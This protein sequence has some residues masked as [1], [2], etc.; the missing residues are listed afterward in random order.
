MREHGTGVRNIRR[1]VALVSAILFGAAAAHEARAAISFAGG[2]A[3]ERF[4][5]YVAFLERDP[6]RF[7]AELATVRQLE[8]SDVEY[9]LTTGGTFER[10]VEGSLTTDGERVLVNVGD[11]KGLSVNSRIAHELEHAR[12]FDDGEIAFEQSP[13]TGQW[14]AHHASYD[15]GDEVRAWTVQLR[16]SV[17]TDFWRRAKGEANP[18]PSMLGEFAKAETDEQR[19]EVL[20]ARGYGNRRLVFGA[21]VTFGASAGYEPRQLVRPAAGRRFF[22]RVRSVF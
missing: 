16:A 11:G 10:S 5:G 9:R 4:R 22:G 3:H 17:E 1:A 12:Q 14:T 18:R 13:A 7:A 15:I 6:E 20:A 21:N 8:Q 2:E 19:A